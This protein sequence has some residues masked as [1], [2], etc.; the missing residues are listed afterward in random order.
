MS[1]L[2]AP[3]FALLSSFPCFLV[4]CLLIS[5]QIS[6]PWPAFAQTAAQT[7]QEPTQPASKPLTARPDNTQP[8]VLDAEAV[9][10]SKLPLVNGQPYD[11]PSLHD[12]ALNYVSDSYGLPALLRTSVRALYGEG[13]GKP[14][15]WGQDFPGF[16]QRFGSSAAVTAIDGNVRF[17]M[18]LAFHEDLRYLPCHR[19]SVKHKIENALLA[20]ITARHGEDGHRS[21]SLTPTIADFSGPIIAHSIWY[22][23][24]SE[25]PEAGVVASRT[26]FATRIGAH[27]FNEFVIDRRKAKKELQ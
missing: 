27:L 21:F 7:S 4:S 17:A 20:E 24:T 10:I 18:E 1:V 2:P 12:L 26:L 15:G 23:G 19:C 11:Q 9:R 6:A 3:S 14:S 13:R 16:A 25:G 5:C 22:P 8:P